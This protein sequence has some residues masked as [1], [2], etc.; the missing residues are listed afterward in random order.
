MAFLLPVAERVNFQTPDLVT[1]TKGTSCH[2]PAPIHLEN[3]VYPAVSKSGF[4]ADPNRQSIFFVVTVIVHPELL[5][6]Y[7]E[8]GNVAFDL[9]FAVPVIA[10][11]HS[12]Y[13]HL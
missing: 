3:R 6:S 10:L 9:H 8:F 1:A 5:A 2:L 13:S 12:I 11:L 7:L 4:H